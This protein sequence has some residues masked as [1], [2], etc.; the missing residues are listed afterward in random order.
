MS[1]SDDGVKARDRHQ[2]PTLEKAAHKAR[3]ANNLGL[4]FADRVN[5]PSDG[6]RARNPSPERSPTGASLR[7]DI[8]AKSAAVDC[9]D[10]DRPPVSCCFDC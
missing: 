5:V 8:L 9:L 7:A 10:S 2:A 6:R 4:D 3:E 1:W